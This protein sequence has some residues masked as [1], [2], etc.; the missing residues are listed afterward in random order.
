M[1]QLVANDPW[2]VVQDG[3]DPAQNRVFESLFSL[4]NGHFGGRGNHEEQ[5]SGDTLRGNY[6]AGI[7]YPDPTR[8]GW[9]KNGYPDYFAKVLNAPDWKALHITVDGDAL[10]L[11]T[12][13]VV[14]YRRILHMKTGE[15]ERHVRATLAERPLGGDRH[16]PVRL[17]DSAAPR[18]HPLPDHAARRAG[19][20]HDRIAEST[21]TSSTRT[22]TTTKASGTPSTRTPPVAARRS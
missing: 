10:D 7:Y 18:S 8:V 15:L 9:W 20:D 14:E 12:A 22:R 13:D 4:G 17:D 6:L 16:G 11:A 2:N 21:A 5:Y 1:K 3:F 19:P